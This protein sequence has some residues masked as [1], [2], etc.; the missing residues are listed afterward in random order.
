MIAAMRNCGAAAVAAMAKEKVIC[1]KRNDAPTQ[2][3]I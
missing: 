2:R 1:R 3:R